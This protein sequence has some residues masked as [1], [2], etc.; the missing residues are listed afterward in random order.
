[1]LFVSRFELA[2]AGIAGLVGSLSDL[3]RVTRFHTRMSS[4]MESP[5]SPS[6]SV[7][8]TVPNPGPDR[9]VERAEPDGTG[10]VGGSDTELAARKRAE[11]EVA[12]SARRL[13]IA[14]N[15][16][17]LGVWRKNLRTGD[18]EWDARMFE[19]F[20]VSELPSFHAFLEAVHPADRSWMTDTWQS[21]A[22][23]RTEFSGR[24]R[25]RRLDGR[26]IHVHTQGVAPID[27]P[28]FDGWVTG[29]DADFTAHYLQQARLR[30]VNE[31][32]DLALSA[33]K[34]GVWEL[35]VET[36]RLIWG[37]SMYALYGL[38]PEE[39]E[40]SIG[41][42][43]S[44]I[45]PDDRTEVEQRMSDLMR[46][47]MVERMEFRI[48]RRSDQEVRVV[49]GNAY[50]KVDSDG[51]AQRAVGM[52]RDIT[53]QKEEE[54]T[55][56]RLEA[57]LQQAQKLET[58]G[59]L[60]GGI[61]HDFNNLL[62]GIMG[63]V[64]LATLVLPPQHEATEYLDA[65]HRA[66]LAARDLIQ[67]ILVFARRGPDS[68][69]QIVDLTAT[70]RSTVALFGRTL[71]S[72]LELVLDLAPGLPTVVGSESQIQRVVMNL[73]VN[74]A[75]AIGDRPGRIRIE[76]RAV[77]LTLDGADG[78]PNGCAPGPHVRLRIADTGS[79]MDE[80]TLQ[81]IFDPF[82][83]TKPTGSGTGLGLS[84]V[85]GIVSDHRGGLKV[86]SVP[87]EGSTFDV[88]LPT[89]SLAESSQVDGKPTAGARTFER[90]KD[91][92]VLV[93]DDEKDVGRFCARALER[94][95]AQ[96]VRF[97]QSPEASRACTV[98]GGWRPVLA[99]LDLAMPE[100]SGVEL[101][102]Q[103]RS[104]DPAV[105]LVLMSGDPSRHAL[106]SYLNDP[107]T[108]I[109][110]KPFTLDQLLSALE[111]LLAGRRDQEASSAT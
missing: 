32:L 48:M 76:A 5:Q 15:A 49:E 95:G 97:D 80:A 38:T 24:F 99:L 20:G 10:R 102:G 19:I 54:Q 63:H 74:A 47:E 60:A 72:N 78:L 33:S 56:R 84:I 18:M 55:R 91:L 81:R 105:L 29:V 107:F 34:F 57:R 58:L 42:W 40:G 69:F 88:F 17:R 90:L 110:R 106:G 53:A 41:V 73:S 96:V 82:F 31:R 71:G 39:F 111:V 13:R 98:G 104:A 3:R 22:A 14:L 27:D 1:M 12:E 59:T 68:P 4:T 86:S 92:K 26:L 65:S 51:R 94:H 89:G 93:V 64:E 52:N 9:V 7:G 109:L 75:Q 79:G 108:R 23:G 6:T 30:D 28:G 16:S 37:E 8:P 85:H 101:A 43:F 35:E 61:A 46:G 100:L 67:R 21:I 45:H 70:L 62:S 2:L 44:C 87:G 36:G 83:T 66:C 11:A 103:L 77:D 50:L 25:Y